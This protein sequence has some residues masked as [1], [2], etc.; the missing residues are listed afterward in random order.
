MYEGGSTVFGP[1]THAAYTQILT[2]LALDMVKGI[3][4]SHPS[5][6]A[7]DMSKQMIEGQT[8]VV[9]DK[10]PAGKHFGSA[11]KTIREWHGR[12]T[13]RPGETVNMTMW[14]SN[15][16]N[17]LRRGNTFMEVQKLEY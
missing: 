6:H 14:A 11:K 15:P 9:L 3:T 7:A 2:E 13:F 10:P 16:R 4:T 1:H 8:G 5:I 17:N 12:D